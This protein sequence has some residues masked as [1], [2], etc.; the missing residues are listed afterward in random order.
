MY[1]V[2]IHI[3]LNLNNILLATKLKNKYRY[4]NFN[5]YQTRN[6]LYVSEVTN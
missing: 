3:L 4:I 1:K 2:I 6:N 5:V